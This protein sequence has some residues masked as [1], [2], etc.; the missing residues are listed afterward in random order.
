MS[1]YFFHFSKSYQQNSQREMFPQQNKILK[2]NR[3]REIANG[4]GAKKMQRMRRG[5]RGVEGLGEMRF[6][7]FA[8]AGCS[9]RL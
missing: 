2:A 1:V 6:C 8:I 5:Q 4:F 7:L 9:L 3:W